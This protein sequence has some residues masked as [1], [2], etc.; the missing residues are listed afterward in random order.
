MA[1]R[2]SFTK[3]R[4]RS[5]TPTGLIFFG[6][7]V[8]PI[9]IPYGDE[10][11]QREERRRVEHHRNSGSRAS[12]PPTGIIRATRGPAPGGITTGTP[13]AAPRGRPT[14]GTTPGRTPPEQWEP[15]LAVRASRPA[16]KL[17]L[18]VPF[19]GRFSDLPPLFGGLAPFYLLRYIKQRVVL[20]CRPRGGLQEPFL[21]G[22]YTAD[23]WFFP[24]PSPNDFVVRGR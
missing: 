18:L 2:S 5:A 3:G 1:A 10:D 8:L 17:L 21:G 20:S 13:G 23:I 24:T 15:R 4:S 16:V 11:D 9:R 6:P 14:G 7:S 22:I 12:R 19:F